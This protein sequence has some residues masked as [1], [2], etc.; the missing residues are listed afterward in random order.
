[1]IEVIAYGFIFAAIAF[2]AAAT[3]GGVTHDQDNHIYRK[4]VTDDTE[5]N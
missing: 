1:M 3:L 4:D 2:M 5:G